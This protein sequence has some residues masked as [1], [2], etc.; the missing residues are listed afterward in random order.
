MH[1]IQGNKQA[2][3]DCAVFLTAA[4]WEAA[5]RAAVH[6]IETAG[7]AVK[8]V[9]L[10]GDGV[11][12]ALQQTH[13]GEATDLWARLD[14]ARR[15]HGFRLGACPVA[16]RRRGFLPAAREGLDWAGLPALFEAAARCPDWRCHAPPP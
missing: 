6:E 5:A 4:P 3:A 2:P 12:L 10:H 15:A 8:L 16:A 9:L 14:A 13:T 1:A 11:L 7:A